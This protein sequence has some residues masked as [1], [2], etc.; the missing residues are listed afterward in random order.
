MSFRGVASESNLSPGQCCAKVRGWASH[1]SPAAVWSPPPG[2]SGRT[3]LLLHLEHRECPL[4]APHKLLTPLLGPSGRA[5]LLLHLEHR[6]CLSAGPHKLL[7]TGQ[8]FFSNAFVCLESEPPRGATEGPSP[9]LCPQA[10][11]PVPSSTQSPETDPMKTV[12]VLPSM[13]LN[14][15]HSPSATLISKD[16]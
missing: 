1:M 6:K 12:S 2:P 8:R 13:K 11:L 14:R 4:G 3:P 15:V 5:P 16:S 9:P 7:A 10:L